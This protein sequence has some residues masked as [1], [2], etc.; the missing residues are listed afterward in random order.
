LWISRVWTGG[1]VKILFSFC[2][3]SEDDRKASDRDTL[4]ARMVSTL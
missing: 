1:N 4:Q 3:F 2:L